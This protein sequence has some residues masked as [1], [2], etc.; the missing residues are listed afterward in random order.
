MRR[1]KKTVA[2]VAMSKEDLRKFAHIWFSHGA[3]RTVTLVKMDDN[4]EWVGEQLAQ[5]FADSF[6]AW[7]AKQ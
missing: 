7:E 3:R 5:N 4:L 2:M 1:S 6:A